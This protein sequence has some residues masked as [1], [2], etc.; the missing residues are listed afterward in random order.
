MKDEDQCLPWYYPQVIPDAR[1]CSP[2]EAREL[3]TMINT[4]SN[5]KCKVGK[6][7]ISVSN[8]WQPLLIHNSN[9]IFLCDLQYELCHQPTPYVCKEYFVNPSNFEAL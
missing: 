8:S 9:E 3:R 6:I 4:M 2:F 5:K 7:H 1:L